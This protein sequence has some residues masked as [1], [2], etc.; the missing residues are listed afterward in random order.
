MQDMHT[1]GRLAFVKAS[2]MPRIAKY[3]DA[4]GC[5]FSDYSRGATERP[6]ARI[7]DETVIRCT[8][9]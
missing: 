5:L 3:A 2:R 9:S 7:P 4:A 6:D 8:C 1:S